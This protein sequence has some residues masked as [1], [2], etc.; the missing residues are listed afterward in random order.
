MKGER[1]GRMK[2][3]LG[4]AAK[5]FLSALYPEGITCDV[6]GAELV[7]DT[8]YTLCADCLKRMPFITGHRCLVCGVPIKD[9]ADYCLRCQRTES[10]FSKNIAPLRYDGDARKL[11]Y[12]LK[13]GKKKY[14]AALLGAMMSDEYIRSGEAC[15][16]IVPVPMSE[17][18]VRK[19]GFNQSVLLA[20]EVGRR[21]DMPVLPALIKQR[22]TTPQ[23]ELTGKERA[24]N[25]KG[26]FSAAYTDHIKGRK[27]LLVDDVFTTGATADECARTLLKAKVRSV[28]VLTAA[29]TVPAARVEPGE[30]RTERNEN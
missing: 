18:E 4:R 23:K 21:L 10:A 14:I 8:R 16:V 7:A 27:I 11:V 29:V 9:E 15:E 28:T 13:F 1:T 19:R 12:S 17:A 3:A 20:E 2:E 6:C 24:E 5:A 22:D 30:A 25:L 26:C